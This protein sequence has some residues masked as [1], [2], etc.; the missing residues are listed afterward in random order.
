M[1]LG[2]RLDYKPQ[3][4]LKQRPEICDLQSVIGGFKPE[5]AFFPQYGRDCRWP[6]RHSQQR[7]IPSLS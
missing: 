4:E 6:Q 3:I 1:P 5:C 7:Q 2:C